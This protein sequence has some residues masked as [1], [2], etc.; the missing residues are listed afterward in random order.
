MT[1]PDPGG[2]ETPMARGLPHQNPLQFAAFPKSDAL[3]Q[4]GQEP[5]K[6][7]LERT[8]PDRKPKPRPGH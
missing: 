8:F 1:T 3:P 7:C 2:S 6:R 4:H 5:D